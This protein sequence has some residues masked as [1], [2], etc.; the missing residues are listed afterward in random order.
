MLFVF[1]KN[2]IISY[3]VSASVVAILFL[4]SISLV[5]NKDIELIQISSNVTNNII[6]NEI[7]N[8]NLKN[9]NNYN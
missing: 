3:I 8:N 9:D 1:N 6:S 5:P 4:F 7:Q 2:K